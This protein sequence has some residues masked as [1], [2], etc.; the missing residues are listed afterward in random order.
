MDNDTI[1]TEQYDAE[2]AM[3]NLY[4][5]WAIA[6]LSSHIIQDGWTD[7]RIIAA[8]MRCIAAKLEQVQ[9]LLRHCLPLS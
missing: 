7:N 5:A 4:D 6:Q 8:Q 9:F 1:N 3:D 2:L